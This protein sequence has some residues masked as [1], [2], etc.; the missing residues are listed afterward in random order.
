MDSNTFWM[1]L[2]TSKI[3]TKSGSADLLTITNMLQRIQENMETSWQKYDLCQYG[4]QEI[5]KIENCVS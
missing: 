5:R 2:G 3:L 1:I 4:T